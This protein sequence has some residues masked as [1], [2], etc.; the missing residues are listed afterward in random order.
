MIT[1]SRISKRRNKLIEKE[2]T[3]SSEDTKYEDIWKKWKTREKEKE[4][5]QKS[6]LK[7]K[8]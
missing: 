7:K 1:D 2:T 6:K 3:V 5:K 8:K 4:G